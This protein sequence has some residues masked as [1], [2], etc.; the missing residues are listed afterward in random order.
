MF[1]RPEWLDDPRFSLAGATNPS[2]RSNRGRRDSLD[3]D[4]HLVRGT[5]TVQPGRSSGRPDQL[6]GRP[7]GRHSS[8]RVAAF[9]GLSQE[10][11]ARTG[12]PLGFPSSSMRRNP[13]IGSTT[14]RGAHVGGHVARAQLLRNA[15]RGT[16]SAWSRGVGRTALTERFNGQAARK[17]SDTSSLRRTLIRTR[18]HRPLRS[19]SALSSEVHAATRVPRY[20]FS[21]LGRFRM[22]TGR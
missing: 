18:P 8:R 21:L 4:V 16:S 17:G 20:E 5:P 11:A 22:R 2:S 15:H 9:P 10:I 3:R 6:D 19:F 14:P 7:G 13:S 1:G 12:I